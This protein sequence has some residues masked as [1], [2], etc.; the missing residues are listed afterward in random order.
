VKGVSKGIPEQQRREQALGESQALVHAAIES[1]PFDFFVL[2]P[3][4]R[5]V[6]QNSIVRERWGDLIGKCPQDIAQDEDTLAIWLENHAKAFRGEVVKGE[7]TLRMGGQTGFYYSLL[8]PIRVGKHVRGILGVNIDIGECRQAED[9]LRHRIDMEKVVTGISNRF[10]NLTSDQIDPEINE[11]LKMIGEFAAVDRSYVFQFSDPLAKMDNTHEWC[12]DGIE[13]QIENLQ[14]L[15]AQTFPWWMKK[16]RRFENIHIPRVSDLPPEAR[17]ERDILRSQAIQSLAVVPMAYG[18]S[19]VGFLG[20]DSVR[21]EKTWTPEDIAL[22]RMVGEIFVNA[23][24][25]KRSEET[26]R[27]SEAKYRQLVEHAPA[28]I[29]EVDLA[30]G[31]FISSNDVLCDYLG[32]SRQELLGMNAFD[33]LADES[34]RQQFSDRQAKALAGE[35]VRETAEYKLKRKDN[36][37]IWVLV[38]VR[39]GREEGKPLTAG[40]VAYDIT[41]RKQIEEELQ[42]VAK[43]EALGVLAGGI[44]HDFNNILTAIVGNI[45]LAKMDVK[46]TGRLHRLLEEAETA[47]SRA[48]A[49]TQQLLTFSRGGAPIKREASISEV[50]KDTAG[51]VLR[52]SKARCDFMLPEDLWP[53]ELDEG[54]ISQVFHNLIINTDQAM[55]DGGVIR[56]RAENLM[57]EAGH[58]LPLQSGRYI[59][60]SIQDQGI[61][62]PEEHLPKIFDPYF[63]TKQRGSGLGLATAYSIIRRHDG[64]ITLESQ[65][66]IGTTVHVYLP[67]SEKK[68]TKEEEEEAKPIVGKGRILVMDDEQ[69]IRDLAQEMLTSIGYAAEVTRDGTEAIE[70]FKK[71]RES[72]DPFDAVILDLTVPGGMGGREAIA[73]L[74]KVDPEVIAIVS[75]GYSTDPIMSDFRGY[76]FSGVAAKPYKI[77]DLSR[78]LYEVLKDRV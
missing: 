63:T 43:L 72:G 56:V 30:T 12:A 45:S 31:K 35:A 25:R 9:A 41:E 60:V 18:G 49:L 38:N 67:A 11:A 68:F 2:G 53:T 58:S 23:L 16:L 17:A 29:C 61:G 64:H 7:V 74:L 57:I 77:Q 26:L 54:Q 59:H 13:S 75:S 24:E 6:V 21:D 10:I 51:F 8:A 55:P 70:V 28:G 20:F 44:A 76:G 1:L 39:L 5:Y 37:E 27:E 65:L 48:R 15:S 47:A 34:D 36:R 50:I 4:G 40:I 62:I 33:F 46:R 66:G 78:V 73:Q 19:L 42:K 22:L 69:M 3:D 52:G 14:G 71:A 32:Y